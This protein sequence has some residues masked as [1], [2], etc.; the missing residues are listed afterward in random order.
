MEEMTTCDRIT[1]NS[2]RYTEGTDGME[3]W[4]ILYSEQVMKFTWHTKLTTK[5]AENLTL[6]WLNCALFSS[7]C[8]NV[9]PTQ[10]KLSQMYQYVFNCTEN[11]YI[12]FW[13]LRKTG[14]KKR[15]THIH[16]HTHTPSTYNNILWEMTHVSRLCSC[17]SPREDSNCVPDVHKSCSPQR[18]REGKIKVV[19]TAV[20]DIQLSKMNQ[21]WMWQNVYVLHRFSAHLFFPL[22]SMLR[23][24]MCST[25][26]GQYVEVSLTSLPLPFCSLCF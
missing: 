7:Y 13:V 1:V 22:S 8:V 14:I 11:T 23:W 18:G 2:Q 19:S 3:N 6:F 10:Y 24:V 4:Q 5:V 12:S 25:V 17:Y 16:M 9:F 21:H 20:T 26:K 15:K